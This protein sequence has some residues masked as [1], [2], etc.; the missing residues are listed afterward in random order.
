MTPVQPD[1]YK[2]KLMTNMNKYVRT[3]RAGIHTDPCK[4]GFSDS[5]NLRKVDLSEISTNPNLTIRPELL[6]D[7][8]RWIADDVPNLIRYEASLRADY[9]KHNGRAMPTKGRTA[10]TPIRES[11]LNLPNNTKD[12]DH[13]VQDFVR[14]VE[15]EHGVRCLRWF[16]HR[17]EEY[18]DPDTGEKHFNCHAHIVWAWYDWETHRTLKLGKQAMSR[19]QDLAS[20]ITGMERG[21]SV[22]ETGS[23]HLTVAEWKNAQERQRGE[24]L[25]ERNKALQDNILEKEETI[26]SMKE[27]IGSLD[28]AIKQRGEY[29]DRTDRTLKAKA[30]QVP[31]PVKGRFGYNTK[32]VDRYIEATQISQLVKV[33][34]AVYDDPSNNVRILKDE[35][36]HLMETEKKYRYLKSTPSELE[37]LLNIH[38][39]RHEN[40]LEENREDIEEY[41]WTSGEALALFKEFRQLSAKVGR[42]L[43]DTYYKARTQNREASDLLRKASKESTI[44]GRIEA[45]AILMMVISPSIATTMILIG[46]IIKACSVIDSIEGRIL[47]QKAENLSERTAKLEKKFKKVEVKAEKSGLKPHGQN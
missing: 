31:V 46:L 13:M 18:T 43:D 21:I 35:I 19:W 26:K 12:T 25:R 7:N 42:E 9:K 22:K 4:T 17:D 11:I 3:G 41:I 45:L 2:L 32:D 20:Q 28:F 14:Q 30:S 15:R 16:I 23:E 1:K 6:Q 36:C 40:R 37:K 47:R 10:S 34:S 24:E 5:H 39:T 33:R 44:S 29:M 8:S 27:G 38:R